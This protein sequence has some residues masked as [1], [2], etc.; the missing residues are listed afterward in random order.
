MPLNCIAFRCCCPRLLLVLH[1]AVNCNVEASSV[2]LGCNLHQHSGIV[3]CAVLVLFALRC[4][5]DVAVAL[6]QDLLYV[7]VGSSIASVVNVSSAVY[8]PVI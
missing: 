3:T 2:C 4:N 6:R 7:E 8:C 1:L 5:V